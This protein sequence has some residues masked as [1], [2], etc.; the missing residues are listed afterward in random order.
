MGMSYP[1]DFRTNARTVRPAGFQ[2]GMLT[3]LGQWR[4][5]WYST[6]GPRDSN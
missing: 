5:A 6:S 4:G 3:H 2:F 1:A